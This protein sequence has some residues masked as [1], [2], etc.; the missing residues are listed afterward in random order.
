MGKYFCEF[1][2]KTLLSDKLKSR[3]MHVRGAKHRLMRKAYYMETFEQ[4]EVELKSLLRDLENRQGEVVQGT[5]AQFRLPSAEFPADFE[6][7]RE[8]VGFR[9]PP[10]FNFHDRRNFPGDIAEA[11]RK[12][13]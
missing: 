4:N 2:N 13:T 9:L 5:A 8:P 11:I 10:N 7:P 12:Y 1:C 6:V 3:R